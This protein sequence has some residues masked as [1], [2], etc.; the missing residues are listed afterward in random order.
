MLQDQLLLLK[1]SQVKI[2]V[3]CV[4]VHP[5]PL[6]PLLHLIQSVFLRSLISQDHCR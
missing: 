4:G 3:A 1:I 2:R 6:R 5:P